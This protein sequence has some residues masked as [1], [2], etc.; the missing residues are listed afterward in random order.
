M[1]ILDVRIKRDIFM[2]GMNLSQ[3]VKIIE[4]LARKYSC[5]KLELLSEAITRAESK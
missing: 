2:I 3:E 5:N 1:S 4:G